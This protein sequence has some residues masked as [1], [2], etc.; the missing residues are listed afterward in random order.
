VS[1]PH[2]FTVRFSIIRPHAVARL[3]LPRPPHPVP[4]VRDD[5]DTPLSR[6]GIAE[7]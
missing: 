4:N 2:D 5:R 3:T 1:G 6:D 7:L